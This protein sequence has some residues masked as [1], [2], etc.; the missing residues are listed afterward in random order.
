MR[1]E[2]KT[3]SFGVAGAINTVT[4]T[5]AVKLI[6]VLC[7]VT[8]TPGLVVMQ[9]FSLKQRLRLAVQPLWVVLA[10]LNMN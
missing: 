5:A 9:V 3:L 1:Q 2:K 10:F 4:G 8:A 6:P 7:Q